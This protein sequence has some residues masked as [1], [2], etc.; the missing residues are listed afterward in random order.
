LTIVDDCCFSLIYSFYIDICISIFLFIQLAKQEQEKLKRNAKYI[1]LGT[2]IN[3]QANTY[4]KYNICN[5]RE[6]SEERKI[7]A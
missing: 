1:I 7:I 4:I 5:L 2:F 6:K 3:I